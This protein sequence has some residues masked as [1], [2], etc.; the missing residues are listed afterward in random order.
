M[1]QLLATM[2]RCE[3]AE[4]VLKLCSSLDGSHSKDP[5]NHETSR[6]SALVTLGK[7][8]AD[9]GRYSDAVQAYKHAVAILPPYYNSR[10]L[11][12]L[13]GDALAQLNRHREAEMWHKAA[14]EVGPD[15]V[16][17]HLSYGKWLAKNVS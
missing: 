1:G 8:H 14:L 3:E 11:F 15:H 12:S 9:R 4:S 2:G 5:V 13:Y 7:L 6:V 10:V 17:A 16:P